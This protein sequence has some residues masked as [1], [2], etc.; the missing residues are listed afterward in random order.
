MLSIF[1]SLWGWQNSE[2]LDESIALGKISGISRVNWKNKSQ[3]GKYS[4]DKKF[5]I[6]N[7]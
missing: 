1:P 5:N 4:P 6:C 3:W 2:K 7:K